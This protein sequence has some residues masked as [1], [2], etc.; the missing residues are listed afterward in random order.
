LILIN[1]NHIYLPVRMSGH[2]LDNKNIL[3]RKR[4]FRC[5]ILVHC[6]KF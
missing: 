1:R 6:L 5:D 2:H 4:L 3:F